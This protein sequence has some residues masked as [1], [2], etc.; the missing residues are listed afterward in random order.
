VLLIQH[1][2]QTSMSSTQHPFINEL[3]AYSSGQQQKR[4]RPCRKHLHRT[5]ILIFSRHLFFIDPSLVQQ[6]DP[7]VPPESARQK[8]HSNANQKTNHN[9]H[10]RLMSV[11]VLTVESLQPI[12]VVVN[13]ANCSR[14]HQAFSGIRLFNQRQGFGG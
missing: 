7:R 6:N 11:H 1:T 9:E 14:G 2:C 3:C 10:Y 12:V 8:V 4:N 5:L 13:R